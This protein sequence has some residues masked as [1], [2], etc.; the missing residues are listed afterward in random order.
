MAKGFEPE[1][2]GKTRRGRRGQETKLT[3]ERAT[4]II[5]LLEAGNFISTAASACGVYPKTVQKWMAYGAR[6]E[7][8]DRDDYT[9]EEEFLIWF[10]WEARSAM[11]RSEALILD[12]L[13]KIGSSGV[14]GAVKALTW[15][16]ER[17][18][19]LK[20]GPKVLNVDGDTKDLQTEPDL[21]LL[22]D[23][24]L[25]QLAEILAAM[26]KDAND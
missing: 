4:R 20:W 12:T 22:S 19:P 6:L 17:R 13:Y 21:S 1:E 23:G 10:T 8:Q 25:D 24:Q 14:P 9:E 2:A 15:M 3:E 26:E 16:L 18:H 11:A 5:E 7:E